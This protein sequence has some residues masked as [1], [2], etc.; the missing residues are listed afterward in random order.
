MKAFILAAGYGKRLQ[1]L[2]LTLPKPLVSV[3]GKPAISHVIDRLYLEG[4]NEFVVN[5]FYLGEKIERYLCYIY[6]H[7]KLYFSKEDKLLDSGGGVKRAS[8]FLKDSHFIIHNSDIITSF[9]IRRMLEYHFKT[10]SDITLA[11]SDR[12]SSRKLC[13]D[14]DM[15]LCGWINEEKK[16]TMG[17]TEGSIRLSFVGV[18]I[19]S[20]KIFDFMPD[21]DVFGIFDF[22]I[23]NIGRLKIVGY[24]I[25]PD[26]WYDIGDIEKLEV[27][28]KES[29]FSV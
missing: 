25:H 18:H 9:D 8:F 22:Y 10:K 5:L 11:V 27:I 24:N 19:A 14:K 20:P 15:N 26:Y 1:P 28:R 17:K 2:T 7:I 4:I 29:R 23:N 12:Q 6:P 13:F 21:D 3:W 16:I